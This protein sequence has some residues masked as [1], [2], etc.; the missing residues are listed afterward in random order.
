MLFIHTSIAN[1]IS[2][3]TKIVL[4]EKVLLYLKFI[5]TNMIVLCRVVSFTLLYLVYL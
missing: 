2:S 4:R 3:S 5:L 1:Y